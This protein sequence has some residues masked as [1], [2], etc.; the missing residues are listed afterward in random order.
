MFTT[1]IVLAY[2][3]SFVGSSSVDSIPN[4]KYIDGSQHTVNSLGITYTQRVFD[5]GEYFSLLNNKLFTSYRI[6]KYSC[7]D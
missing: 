1:L 6:R 7:L 4:E 5:H 3:C 2:W